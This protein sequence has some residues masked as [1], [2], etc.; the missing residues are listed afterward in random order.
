MDAPWALCERGG[1]TFGHWTTVA[2]QCHFVLA[3]VFG[4]RQIVCFT[5]ADGLAGGLW[6]I[7]AGHSRDVSSVSKT[8]ETIAFQ[9]ELVAQELKN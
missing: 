6:D 4:Y 1:Y 9:H 5:A 3:L 8:R 2:R 7:H